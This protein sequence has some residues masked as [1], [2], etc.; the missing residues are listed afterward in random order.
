MKK[1]MPEFLRSRK[2]IPENTP[3]GF[4]RRRNEEKKMGGDKNDYNE[5]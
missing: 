4:L 5:I 1:T 3:L 2:H